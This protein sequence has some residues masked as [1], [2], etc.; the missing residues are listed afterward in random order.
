MGTPEDKQEGKLQLV[1]KG[2]VWRRYREVVRRAQER[3]ARL[4]WDTT[5]K[6]SMVVKR[7][8]GLE[9]LDDLVTADDVKH[10]QGK[11][12]T[13]TTGAVNVRLGQSE[14]SGKGSSKKKANGTTD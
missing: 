11:D 1:L 5:F 10:F 9:P 13:G 8:L 4:K 3:H 12:K 14:R 2:L 7:L 6:E